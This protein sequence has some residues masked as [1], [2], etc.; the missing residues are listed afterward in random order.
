MKKFIGIFP[1]LGKENV[2]AAL[3]RIVDLCRSNG[4]EPL[5]PRE[6]AADFGAAVYDSRTGAGLE[7]AS[8]SVSLGGD[9]TLLQMARVTA[10]LGLPG[11]GINFGKLGFLAEIDLNTMEQAFKD[12]GKGEYTLEGRSLLQAEV[13]WG[14]MCIAK[15]Q[16]LNDFVL[17]KGAFSKMAHLQLFINGRPSGVY[18]AD[19][20]IVATATGSTAY[21]L[22]AGGPLVMPALDVSIITPVCAHSL[23][24]RT[25]V[26]P[27]S[28]VIELRAV[29]GS[30]EMMLQA[31]GENVAT[32]VSDTMLRITQSPYR[33]NF[34]RLTERGYYETWQQ[35]LLRN[36]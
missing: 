21:S 18:A 12:L 36:L 25:L 5:L 10:P 28:E 27:M 22:S 11:F 8:M 9:G 23:T 17:A 16:A 14:E 7:Q 33:M 24:A 1:N 13:L 6:A 31:D 29:P 15:A 20:I 35:K 34:I 26:I 19:G 4:L 2:L 32:I 30:E 3:P